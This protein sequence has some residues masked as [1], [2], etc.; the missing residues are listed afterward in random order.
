VHAAGGHIVHQFL[1]SNSNK[2]TDQWGGSIENRCRFG[3]AVTKAIVEVLG[4]GRVGTKISPCGGY[5]DVGCV[6]DLTTRHR[7]LT[8][9]WQYVPAGDYPDVYALHHATGA[10]GHRLHSASEV[11][12]CMRRPNVGIPNNTRRYSSSFDFPA[13]PEAQRS[14]RQVEDAAPQ[15]QY[16]RGTPHDVLA[17]YGPL[18][19]VPLATL[20]EH[21]ESS[22]RGPAM[23]APDCGNPTPTR[24]LLNG[25]LSPDEAATLLND[26][27]I[28]AAVFGTMWISN[29]DFQRRLELG[30]ELNKDVDMS[31]L[32]D[33][34]EGCPE[35]GYTDY[36]Y[37]T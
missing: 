24:L 5:N 35:K 32:Y 9:H 28:D 30:K 36:P 25:G 19:K 10:H 23:P 22:F 16:K 31:T 8:R 37:A 29:P 2:R 21:K 1:D 27:L 13:A 11:R 6:H 33:F 12:R 18:V 3:L 20:A 15:N 34:P 26:G 14:I 7:S 17:I 4:A